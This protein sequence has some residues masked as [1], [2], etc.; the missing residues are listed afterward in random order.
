MKVSNVAIAV[1][2]VIATAP[3]L[4]DEGSA[5]NAVLTQLT[6]G[7]STGDLVT[8]AGA[9]GVGVLALSKAEVAI[10]VVKRIFKKA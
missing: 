3:V 4:A 8:A 2:S 1:V 6:A 9:I 10:K 5:G 7:L